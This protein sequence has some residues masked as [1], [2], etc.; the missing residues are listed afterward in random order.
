MSFETFLGVN[1]VLQDNIPLVSRTL[2]TLELVRLGVTSLMLPP[3]G[4]G[5]SE[6]FATV[7]TLVQVDT[8]QMFGQHVCC[9]LL[10]LATGEL[11][12]FAHVKSACG[13]FALVSSSN[14]QTF[15]LT[16]IDGMF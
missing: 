5:I 14:F 2:V 1:L 10:T 6:R 4:P 15:L 8:W 3:P 7:L 9:H 13:I 12:Q 11:T 16:N